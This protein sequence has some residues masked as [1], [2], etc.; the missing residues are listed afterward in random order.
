MPRA[1]GQGE[2]R[3]LVVDDHPIVRGGLIALLDTLPGL[4]VV[5]EA[6][7]GRDAV[8]LARR[9]RPD[10]VVM[11]LR[12]PDLDGVAA[13]RV[14]RAELPD[15]AV[16]VLT[17]FDEDVLVA[18]ALA[19]G[20]RGYL[21]KG[22]ES[23]EI[24]RAVRAVA[25]GVAIFSPTVADQVLHRA[26]TPPT[27]VLTGLTPRERDVLDLVARGLG[28]AAIAGRL[29]LSPKTVGNHVSALFGKLGV[30]TRA[31]AVVRAREAGLGTG[32]AEPVR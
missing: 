24:D 29:G 2:I 4:V 10:V 18:A 5:G 6:G 3:V 20:A 1:A 14:I 22:A 31:E 25:G 30:A 26:G 19:A 32:P 13:T 12:M 21:L 15:T 17:M 27:T 8:A 28:N 7:T 11:D 9:H 16:L 23:A